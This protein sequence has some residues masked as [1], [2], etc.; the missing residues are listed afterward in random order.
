[1]ATP[2]SVFARPN[3]E[4]WGEPT[5]IDA[6]LARIL[7]LTGMG[8]RQ[9]SNVS[10]VPLF[11]CP[12]IVPRVPYPLAPD[13]KSCFRAVI[14]RRHPY[15]AQLEANTLACSRAC[16]LVSNYPLITDGRPRPRK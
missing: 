4:K 3:I 10:I 8:G 1:M 15:R 11:F 14:S 16:S 5:Q 12:A 7:S 6:R 2:H 13:H 9:T